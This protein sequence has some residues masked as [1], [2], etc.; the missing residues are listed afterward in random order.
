M[1]H[2][3]FRAQVKRARDGE[4]S[5]Q[6]PDLS[7]TL[8]RVDNGQV[9]ELAR[10]RERIGAPANLEPHEPVDA[11]DAFHIAASLATA[12]DELVRGAM[13]RLDEV[14]GRAGAS[15]FHLKV[16]SLVLELEQVQREMAD[17]WGAK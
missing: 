10:F 2:R 14:R 17:R 6:I 11:E 9:V 13:R 7:E 16:G 12:R 5:G 3:E 4:T 15:D 1:T 8:D